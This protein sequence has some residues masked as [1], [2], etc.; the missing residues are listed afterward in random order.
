MK[1][2]PA[3]ALA[4]C[5][6]HDIKGRKP[7]EIIDDMLIWEVIWLSETHPKTHHK[8]SGR[9]NPSQYSVLGSSTSESMLFTATLS[10]IHY[11]LVRRIQC[12]RLESRNQTLAEFSLG[13]WGRWKIWDEKNNR[14]LLKI[15]II[16]N[17][18]MVI[19]TLLSLEKANFCT[20]ELEYTL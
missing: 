13:N 7:T 4:S 19:D 15:T 5:W 20:T 10:C 1:R 16:M 11:T 6:R 8:N 18:L 12:S 2:F 14:L 17:F 9:C 3:I